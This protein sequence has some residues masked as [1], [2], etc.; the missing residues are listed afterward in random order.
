[1]VDIE[2][3]EQ[4]PLALATVKELL[5]AQKS[6]VKELNF[7]ST[8]VETYVNDFVE[9]SEEVESIHKKLQ[10]TFPRLREKHIIKVIDI[11]PQDINA[12]KAVFTGETVSFKQEELKQMLDILNG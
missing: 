1:M 10:E 12:L 4:K 7:R 11:M 5:E 3:M 9:N 6:K 8:K 2:V